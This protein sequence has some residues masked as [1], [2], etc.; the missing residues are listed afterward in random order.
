V[1]AVTRRLDRFCKPRKEMITLP[2]QL[3]R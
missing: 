2:R 3:R 1:L